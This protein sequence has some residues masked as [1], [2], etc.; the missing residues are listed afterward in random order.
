MDFDGIDDY[1]VSAIAK[2]GKVIKIKHYIFNENLQPKFGNFSEWVLND[3]GIVI[4]QP[5]L[6]FAK[7][8]SQFLG[9]VSVPIFWSKGPIP[10]ADQNPDSFDRKE[11]V[12]K[13]LYYLVPVHVNSKIELQT[14]LL[15]SEFNINQIRKKTKA[16]F[17]E[18][19]EFIHFKVEENGEVQV[20]LSVGVASNLKYYIAE[21]DLGK[22]DIKITDLNLP[23]LNLSYHSTKNI[24]EDKIAFFGIYK[25]D[26]ARLAIL[27]TKTLEIEDYKLLSNSLKNT[28]ISLLSVREDDQDLNIFVEGVE[29]FLLYKV[30]KVSHE[31][32]SYVAPIDRFSYLPGQ[33]FTDILYPIDVADRTAIYV[34]SSNINSRNIHSSSMNDKG[35]N[36]P[37]KWSLELPQECTGLNPQKLFEE[38][39]GASYIIL[40]KEGLSYTLKTYLL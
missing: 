38:D 26:L 11:S 35:I 24:T 4:H 1:F 19:L 8:N 37:I 30:N 40:C 25:N 5:S 33:F 28:I 17:D 15:N 29:S 31:I 27:N 2:E 12:G 13:G 36:T 22:T 32:K 18:E 16:R 14:R 20:L 21:F 7:W 6:K 3:E 39:R 9:F 23:S 10:V 34:D